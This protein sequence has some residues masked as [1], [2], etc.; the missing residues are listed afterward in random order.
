MA[1]R[2][3]EGVPEAEDP[4]P[5]RVIPEMRMPEDGS[6]VSMGSL[7][8]R[9]RNGEDDG[10]EEEYEE[11]ECEEDEEDNGK[12]SS[13]GPKDDTAGATTMVNQQAKKKVMISR[14]ERRR[15]DRQE[16][17]KEV[18]DHLELIKEFEGIVSDEVLAK[19]KNDL[20]DAIPLPQNDR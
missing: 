1:D 19:R 3:N 4:N 9:K 14:E 16:L 6:G 10:E 11:E 18:K 17:L 2:V 13:A 15:R 20:F 12:S 8:G 5:D 7:S